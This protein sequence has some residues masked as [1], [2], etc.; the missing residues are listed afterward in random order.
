MPEQISVPLCKSI[1][2]GTQRF[3][4]GGNIDMKGGRQRYNRG[5]NLSR[6]ILLATNAL[7]SS[8]IPVP[9]GTLLLSQLATPTT[10]KRVAYVQVV[11]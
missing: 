9:S 6:N 8:S 1:F 10:C 7:A 11:S 4:V 3:G 5:N 2:C